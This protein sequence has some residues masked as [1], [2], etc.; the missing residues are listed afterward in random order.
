MIYEGF[1]MITNFLWT[2]KCNC[3]SRVLPNCCNA[4][5]SMSLI[6]DWVILIY[7]HFRTL[8]NRCTIVQELCVQKLGCFHAT[9][10]CDFGVLSQMF[11]SFTGWLYHSF[12]SLQWSHHSLLLRLSCYSVL[13]TRLCWY[14][15]N[16][17]KGPLFFLIQEATS[18]H[19]NTRKWSYFIMS[20]TK[21]S[22]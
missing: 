15:I 14:P 6:S 3:I 16:V 13:N 12:S 8:G 22:P 5:T 4:I 21:K 7:F 2:S 18:V 20:V 9:N 10:Y 19:H 17:R 11:L 1:D